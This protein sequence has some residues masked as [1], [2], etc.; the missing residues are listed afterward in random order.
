MNILNIVDFDSIKYKKQY[1]DSP[2]VRV[3]H[4]IDNSIER[5]NFSAMY[6]SNSYG[7]IQHFL[8][9]FPASKIENNDMEFSK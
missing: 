7:W 5:D 2:Q 9:I 8:K 1:S 6:L 4:Q 3:N